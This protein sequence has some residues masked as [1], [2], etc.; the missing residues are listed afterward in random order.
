MII[1]TGK[2]FVRTFAKSYDEKS[3]SAESIFT[4]KETIEFVDEI[5]ERLEANAVDYEW[6]LGDFAVIDNLAMA[7][8]ASEGTQGNRDKVGLRILHRTTVAGTNKPQKE[9]KTARIDE[10]LDI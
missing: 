5:S 9:K 1:H 7:H 2:P 3:G 6:E 8:F 10:K 4:E